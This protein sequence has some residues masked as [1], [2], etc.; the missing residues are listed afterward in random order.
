VD[1]SNSYEKFNDY[2]DFLI[3]WTKQLFI[4]NNTI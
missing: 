3:E 1:K 4:G 2:N